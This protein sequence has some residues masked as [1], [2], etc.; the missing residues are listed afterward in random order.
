MRPSSRLNGSDASWPSGVWS[1]SQ[2]LCLSLVS[3]LIAYIQNIAT[4]VSLFSHLMCNACKVML[5]RGYCQRRTVWKPSVWWRSLSFLLQGHVVSVRAGFSR[6]LLSSLSHCQLLTLPRMCHTSLHTLEETANP[7]RN[8]LTLH[9]V[10]PLVWIPLTYYS[11]LTH[12]TL[13]YA[14]IKLRLSVYLTPLEAE[15]LR[16]ST[17]FLFIIILLLPTVLSKI[18]KAFGKQ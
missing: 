18:L 7:S 17:K 1:K 16:C 14:S 13:P 9:P 12:T 10:L 15:N 4:I 8:F 6:K 2:K 11:S 5:R 3:I